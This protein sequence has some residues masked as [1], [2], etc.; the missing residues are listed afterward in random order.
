M[1][2]IIGDNFKVGAAS[3]IDSRFVVENDSELEGL[4][5]YEGLI[6]YCKSK[7]KYYRYQNKQWAEIVVNTEEELITLI[8]QQTTAAMEFKGTINKAEFDKM[9]GDPDNPDAPPKPL[10]HAKLGDFYKVV[11]DF[12]IPAMCSATGEDVNVYIGDSIVYGR[13][14]SDQQS[15][16]DYAWHVIPSGDDIEDTWRVV[17]VDDAVFLEGGNT[18]NPIN[19]KAGKNVTLST[20]ANGTLTISAKDDDSHHE[21]KMVVTGDPIY[22]QEDSATDLDNGEVYLNIVENNELR[23]SHLIE[24]TDG[25]KVK[26]VHETIGEGEEAEIIGKI[27]VE[28]P[29]QKYRQVLVNGDPI[30]LQDDETG[31]FIAGDNITL[32]ARE[33]EVDEMGNLQRPAG[34]IISADVEPNTVREIK[35]DGVTISS[36]DKLDE[37]INF[38]SGRGIVL[39]GQIK[40]LVPEPGS[41]EAPYVEI[42]AIPYVGDNVNINIEYSQDDHDYEVKHTG[43][44]EDTA[45]EREWTMPTTYIADPL[46]KGD[47]EEEGEITVEDHSVIKHVYHDE[48]GH[49]IGV[50]KTELHKIATTGSIYDVAEGSNTGIDKDGNDIQ[51]L[52][53]DCNW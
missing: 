13:S 5:K 42:N 37:A 53:L 46:P 47:D 21:A 3:P 2:I 16:D 34:I 4:L 41:P 28:A 24:G 22:G 45:Q 36:S 1:A 9:H 26:W 11:E 49:V 31:A 43:P 51:Y 14:D 25:A 48:N 6:V 33:K 44:D 17:K 38:A 35:V 7:A 39:S 50:E 10:P 20:D 18:T 27:V 8:E 30:F 40:S 19:F 29:E 23:S 12:T 32:T 52:I 15:Y